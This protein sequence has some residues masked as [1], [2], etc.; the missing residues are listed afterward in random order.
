MTL[1][2]VEKN[3]SVLDANSMTFQSLNEKIR[4][5]VYDGCKELVLNNVCGQRYIGCGLGAGINITINGVPGNDMAMFMGGTRLVVNGNVQ[6]CVANTMDS[7]EI[8]VHGRSGDTLGHGMR[9]GEV[10]IRDC[11]GT[12]V[13]IHMK[14]YE[15]K[16]PVLVIGGYAGNFLGEYMAGGILILLGL[17]RGPR[18]IVGRFVAT[19]MHGGT[20]YIRGQVDPF[21]LGKEVKIFDIN[22]KDL[23]ILGRYV[24][25]YCDYFGADYEKIMADKFIKLEPYTHR[26][27]GKLYAY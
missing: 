11:V 5:L 7:G 6:D 8:V 20:M 12:R 2:T 18:D 25:K 3:I 19:G 22:E 10:Y 21:Q 13:G 4:A 16:K 9:G 14:S 1:K 27:Y 26:P 23:Q 15:E 17:N 24:K